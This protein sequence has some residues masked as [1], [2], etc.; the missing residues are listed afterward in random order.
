M[1]RKVEVQPTIA[2]EP[3]AWRLS[4]FG[5]ADHGHAS[6]GLEQGVRRAGLLPR[7]PSAR[8]SSECQKMTAAHSPCHVGDR[9]VEEVVSHRFPLDSGGLA[10]AGAER[11]D[12]GAVPR[13]DVEHRA[14]RSNAVD[15]CRQQPS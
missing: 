15:A 5:T 12:E 3:S 9:H 2:W 4:V 14:R 11:V 6:A 10:A 7:R 8:R 13:A 1:T